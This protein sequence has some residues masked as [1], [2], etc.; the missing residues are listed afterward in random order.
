LRK[1]QEKGRA[2]GA[3]GGASVAAASASARTPTK[4]IEPPD[5]IESI[6]IWLFNNG[7][8]G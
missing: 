5:E 1:E 7:G 3:P 8:A 4:E 6:G 2:E